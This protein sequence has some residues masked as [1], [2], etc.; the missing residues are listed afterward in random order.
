MYYSA[1]TGGFYDPAIHGQNIPADAVEITDDEY[2]N[3]LTAQSSG[4]RIGSDESG[5][6]IL[7]DPAPRFAT[8]ADALVGLKS[9]C[10][11]LAAKKRNAI[12]AG[13]SP[14]E[15]ASWPIK[16][17]EAMAYQASGN[18]ADA[19]M[20]QIEATARGVTLA[21]LATKVL[22]KAALL[23]Q[24]ESGI[25]GTNGKHNDALDALAAGAAT[26]DEMLAYD[27]TTGWPA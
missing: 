26:V 20:L 14:A 2:V 13:I 22:D 23:S 3:L 1:T 12:T 4:R 24:M 5:M 9:D 7:I 18:A 11:A 25:A 19:P 8:V 17:A 10:D 15:M 27:F 6:P 21:A 16:R